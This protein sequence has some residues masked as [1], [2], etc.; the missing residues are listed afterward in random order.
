MGKTLVVREYDTI[1]G[2]ADFKDVEGF[3]CLE[4]KA[5]DELVRFIHEFTGSDDSSDVLEFL[6]VGYKRNVG[7]IVTIKNYVGIIQLKSGFQIEVLPKIDFGQEDKDNKK[8]KRIF[9]NMLRSMKDFPAK[10]FDDASINVDKMNLYEL[11]INMYLQEVRR[12]LKVGLKSSYL[13]QEDNLR[14]FKGKLLVNQNIKYN[15]SHKERVY[16]SYDEFNPDRSENRLIKST[17]L[18]LQRITNS[19]ENSKEIRQLLTSF[20]M[21][22]QSE[23]YDKDFS[24]VAIDRNT[25]QYETLMKWS[26]VFLYNKSFATFSGTTESRAL[27]FPM[28]SVYE[29]Y[30]AQQIKKVFCPDGWEVKCQDKKHYLFTEPKKQFA[31]RPDIVLR[32][33]DRVVIMDTKWKR[34]NNDEK[35]NYGIA[36]SDMYQM[37]AYAKKYYASEV[38]LL[39]PLTRE[40]KDLGII[41]FKDDDIR[42]CVFF[43]DVDLKNINTSMLTLKRTL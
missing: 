22:N 20:E 42:V 17:L 9:I 25:I 33:D 38:W 8:T 13:P 24:R 37:Y 5:F 19:A 21:V 36:Q 16:L 39:Y 4:K 18:K 7:E 26:K 3:K 29:S 2:N 1:I 43:V 34:L 28:E 41:R 40:E 10:V 32:K 30:V 23:N 11:F 12:L 15:A 14:F 27:L 6:R 35:N 31:L